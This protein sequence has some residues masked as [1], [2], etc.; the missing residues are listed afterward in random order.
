M[1]NRKQ[2]S[3][4]ILFLFF[5]VSF[6]MNIL[7]SYFSENTYIYFFT[8]IIFLLYIIL[9]IYING[10][11]ELRPEIIII[12]MTYICFNLNYFLY[13]KYFEYTV[14]IY[15]KSAIYITLCVFSIVIGCNIKQKKIT[16]F[17]NSILKI[18]PSRVFILIICIFCASINFLLQVVG[19]KTTHSAELDSSILILDVLLM[20][21]GALLKIVYFDLFFNLIRGIKKKY[22]TAELVIVIIIAALNILSGSRGSAILSLFIIPYLYLLIKKKIPYKFI[23]IT[24]VFLIFIV[25][26]SLVYRSMD[27]F[28][29]SSSDRTI[30]A[31]LK[32]FV[33][34]LKEVKIDADMVLLVIRY[35]FGRFC[36]IEQSLR[37]I[38]FMPDVVEYRYGT[39]IFPHMFVSLIPTAIYPSRPLM[40]I[41][42]WFG[43]K[44]CF[45]PPEKPVFITAGIMNEFY[46]NFSFFGFLG[47]ILFG[48]FL[49]RLYLLWEKNKDSLFLNIVYYDVF[50]NLIFMFNESYIVSGILTIFKSSVFLFILMC[51]IY[52]IDRNKGKL[53]WE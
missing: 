38:D 10:I 9:Y 34:A 36:R 48:M 15:N 7:V 37:I 27:M 13:K 49:K 24:V 23:I 2:Y 44:F 40:N 16:K 5:L 51:M 3:N 17:N 45:T 14:D 6:L 46:I 22:M 26:F 47:C 21:S 1:I 31:K 41:G 53:S 28:L 25:P 33:I 30:F 8:S 50:F 39:T 12:I 11:I 35:T 20:V 18:Y 42:K 29:D 19:Y 4:I 52:A 43:V 32:G